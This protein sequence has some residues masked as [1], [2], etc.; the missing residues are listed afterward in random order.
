M[1]DIEYL[2]YGILVLATWSILYRENIFYR[3]CEYFVVGFTAANLLIQGYES[4]LKV[5]WTPFMKGDIYWGFWIIISL[6]FIAYFNSKTRSLYMIPISFVIAIGTGIGLRGTI[7]AQIVQQISGAMNSLIQKSGTDTFNQI[8]LAVGTI[9]S[10]SY[11]LFTKE[12]PKSLKAVPNLG[13]FFIMVTMG[14]AYANTGMGR[15]SS[16]ATILLNL[17]KTDAMYFIPIALII[18]AI[19]IIRRRTKKGSQ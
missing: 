7:S 6:G 8:I 1:V 14:A 2:L 5:A 3:I 16:Y 4:A 13:K 9:T 10:L 12:L 15:L 17:W 18:V 11:F 19:D